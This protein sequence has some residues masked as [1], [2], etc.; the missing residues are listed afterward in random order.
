MCRLTGYKIYHFV[1]GT[2]NF[3]NRLLRNKE[4]KPSFERC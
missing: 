3:K 2:P 4:I 1:G